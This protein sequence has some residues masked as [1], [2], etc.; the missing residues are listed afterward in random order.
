LSVSGTDLRREV[1]ALYNQ[2]A[3]PQNDWGVPA[4]ALEG[5]LVEPLR[6]FLPPA[7]PG[8]LQRAIIVPFGVTHL[9]PFAA[10]VG[11]DGPL[12]DHFDV[13]YAAS[14]Q[15]IR[16]PADSG[17]AVDAFGFNDGTLE[18]AEAEASTLGTGVVRVG[19]DATGVELAKTAATARILHIASH[20]EQ[21]E[22]NPFMSAL[23]LA[24]GPFPLYRVLG[25]AWHP[26]LVTLSACSMARGPISAAD[27]ITSPARAFLAAGVPTVI[28]SQWP[29]DDDSAFALMQPFYRELAAG[30]S[31][32][33]ALGDA[34]RAMLHGPAN[35]QH[36]GRW[37][38]FAAYVGGADEGSGAK[39]E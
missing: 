36:P 23:Q 3:E 17:G 31:P 32:A 26:H 14:V 21:D 37:A 33:H 19:K 39:H 38:A 6:P 1:N 8:H 2:L 35:F 28:A 29:V 30:I 9:V 16:P 22:A 5:Q 15:A 4:R 11:A 12:I 20:A 7:T 27:E 25:I 24:D 10:L 13:A 34:Q 18:R